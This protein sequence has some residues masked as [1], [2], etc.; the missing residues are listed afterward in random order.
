MLL[1]LTGNA[2][3]PTVDVSQGGSNDIPEVITVGPGGQ[4]TLRVPQNTNEFGEYHGLG[5]VIY[6]LAGPEGTLSI[7]SVDS[8]LSGETP[9]EQN[10]PTNRLTDIHVISADEFEVQ[11]DTVAVNLL[12]NPGLRDHDADGDFAVI[13]IDVGIDVNGVTGPQGNPING[14]DYVTPG[15]ILYGFEDFVTANDPGYFA[16]GG[17]GGPGTTRR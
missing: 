13:K 2:S 12:D 3:N 14:V 6:G 7:S 11:L 15:S 1:D 17:A 4:I 16:N 8:V 9:T 10:N 5:Y